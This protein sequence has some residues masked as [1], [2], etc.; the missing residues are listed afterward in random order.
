[1]F[2]AVTL[3]SASVDEFEAVAASVKAFVPGPGKV[4]TDEDKLTAY[5]LYKQATV[6]DIN[7]D[8]YAA[9]LVGRGRG[10]PSRLS[11]WHSFPRT[12]GSCRVARSCM[13]RL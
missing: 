9:W 7:T 12:D 8:R 1:M 3:Q 6:G 2:A 13:L 11:C 5:G 4:V 10:T